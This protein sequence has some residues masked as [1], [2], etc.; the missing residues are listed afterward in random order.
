MLETDAQWLMRGGEVDSELVTMQ[1]TWGPWWEGERLEAK[2]KQG[3]RKQ[4]DTS[5]WICPKPVRDQR[6]G[7][8]G[9]LIGR[10]EGFGV[11]LA[12]S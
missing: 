12:A 6:G 4:D 7:G 10:G 3:S 11:E 2:C 1:C 8:E 9:A 5:C